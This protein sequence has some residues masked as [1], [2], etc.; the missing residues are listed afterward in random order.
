MK[1][2]GPISSF[3][4]LTS[5]TNSSPAN[6]DFWFDGTNFRF[7]EGGSSRTLGPVPVDYVVDNVWSIVDNVDQ[8]KAIQFEAGSITASTTRIVTMPDRSITLDTITS[9]TQVTGLTTDGV[10]FNNAGT[11]SANTRLTNDGTNVYVNNN[12]RIGSSANYVGLTVSAPTSYTLRLPGTAPSPDQVLKAGA[13]T[14]T[15]LE[16]GT[17]SSG[18]TIGT[19]TVTSGTSEY[20]LFNSAGVVGNAAELVRDA[21]TGRIEI[22]S[23]IT[24]D[25]SLY[26]EGGANAFY[27]IRAVASGNFAQAIK[28]EATGTNTQAINATTT[29]TTATASAFVLQRYGAA[30][31]T[32][33]QRLAYFS[34]NFNA[35]TPAAGFGTYFTLGLK[36]STTDDVEAAQIGWRWQVATHISRVAELFF[37]V[38]NASSLVSAMTLTPSEVYSLLPFRIGTSANYVGLAVSSPTSHTLTLPGTSPATNRFLKSG[39]STAT[40]LEWGVPKKRNSITVENPLNTDDLTIFFT[41]EAITLTAVRVVLRGSSS[42]SIT[43]SISSGT[44]RST[45]SENNV[46]GQTVTSTTTGTSVTIA[47]SSI[48]ANAFV[49]LRITAVSGT[50]AEAHVTIEYE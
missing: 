29:G 14:A 17:A 39:A 26:V 24:N 12:L 5:V 42:P 7:R 25:A 28:V 6:G 4:R 30:S 33:E 8:S 40:N 36:S 41:T 11:V 48:V 35:N 49:W 16:W 47:D 18:I 3:L 46:S 9:A 34:Q 38:G 21:T 43:L 2:L 50:V 32:T 22:V 1:I 13:V 37:R 10:L 44:D 19:T 27:A 15:N 20:F 31:T 45:V 23:N